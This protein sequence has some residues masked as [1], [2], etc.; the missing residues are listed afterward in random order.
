M[1]K[2]ALPYSAA[3][4]ETPVDSVPRGVRLVAIAF[5]SAFIVALVITT[6]WVSSPQLAGNWLD[7]FEFGDVVRVMLGIAACL[8]MLVHLFRPPKDAHGYQTWARLGLALI[9]LILFAV[10]LFW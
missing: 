7:H 5:R 10:I 9:P 8:W 1:R 3:F 6:A 4:H 2:R